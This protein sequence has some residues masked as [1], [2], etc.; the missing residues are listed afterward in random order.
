MN[1]DTDIEALLKHHQDE[2][3][4]R[5]GKLQEPDIVKLTAFYRQK[6]IDH[7]YD[8]R[9][10]EA[11]RA[12]SRW[13][14]KRFA[15]KEDR[16]LLLFGD[17]GN[18][19]T[20]GVQEIARFFLIKLVWAPAVVGWWKNDKQVPWLEK[21]L[22]YFNPEPLKTDVISYNSDL[23]IDELGKEMEDGMGGVHVPQN[24]AEKFNVLGY[25]L[26][27]RYDQ[28]RQSG[29][30]TLTLVTTNLDDAAIA[31]YYG[32]HILDRFNEMFYRVEFIG[33]TRREEWKRETEF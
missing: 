15:G 14:A 26:A 16:G 12:I 22:P 3:R 2:A 4:Q 21:T 29:R 17:N 28:W 20:M 33:A 8:D 24:Y 19:K 32:R 11:H 30:K 9:E 25:L 5:E 31:G 10:P 1:I 27:M 18:G 13:C 7:G 6:M 23:I